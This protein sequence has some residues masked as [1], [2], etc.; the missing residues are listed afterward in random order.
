MTLQFTFI[1]SI[2]CVVLIIFIIL[3]PCVI[4]TPA[5]PRIT[6]N[7]EDNS[8]SNSVRRNSIQRLESSPNPPDV[9]VQE[10]SV[11]RIR[12][13]RRQ[14]RQTVRPNSARLPEWRRINSNNIRHW[15]QKKTA[16]SRRLRQ[17]LR[18]NNP[19][20]DATSSPQRHYLPCLSP[21]LFRCYNGGSCIFIQAL[22]TR[23]CR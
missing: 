18:R 14:S 6:S 22:Q 16:R 23:L 17:N 15:S 13:S 4:A 10:N 19:V 7:R 20:R 11:R 1:V 3:I 9:G 12:H 21:N 8:N 5:P 2:I